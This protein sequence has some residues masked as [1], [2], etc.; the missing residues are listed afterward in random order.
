[1]AIYNITNLTDGTS[2][3]MVRM[4]YEV[5]SLSNNWVAYMILIVLF[6]IV[7][8]LLL[9]NQKSFSDAFISSSFLILV[10]GLIFRLINING[11]GMIPTSI[12]ILLF[13][14]F[15]ISIALKR[16]FG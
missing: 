15:G 2:T 12:L 3:S 13:I 16:A 9:K 8:T 6:A 1:M 14:L 11:N 10:I 7:L 4:F 5:N